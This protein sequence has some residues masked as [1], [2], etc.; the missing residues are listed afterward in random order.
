MTHSDADDHSSVPSTIDNAALQQRL[1]ANRNY[2][3][4]MFGVG[5][6][7]Q[8]MA[9]ALADRMDVLLC[10]LWRQLAPEL[11]DQVDLIAVGGFGRGELAPHS[12]LDLWFLIP[13]S[14]GQAEQEK[15]QPF[16]YALWD[17]NLKVGYAVRSV[18]D[19]VR[20]MSEDWSTATAAMEAR[21]VF[22]H[23]TLFE[24]LQENI[25]KFFQRR[26]AAFV[27]AK[28][29]EMHLRHDRTGKTA[30]LM[31]PDIK[32]GGGS[33]RDIQTVFWLA[34]AWYGTAGGGSLMTSGTLSVRERYHLLAAEDYL[35]RCRVGLHLNQQRA[36][37]RLSFE[38]QAYL[39]DAMGYGGGERPAVE[40]FMKDYFRHA[41]RVV[42][43]CGM[44]TMHFEE[45]Q[46]KHLFVRT[47]PIGHGLVEEG[48]RVGIA[49]AAVFREEPLRLLK[50]FHVA[51]E[52]HRKLTSTTLRRIRADAL[53]I[54]EDV[55]RDP[56]AYQCF[57]DILRQRRNVAWAL[58]E[59]NDTGVLG[60]FIPDFRRVV[61]LGQFN[62]YH[63]YTVDEHTIRAVGEARNF[64]H[65]QRTLR[66]PLA[67]EISA[68]LARPELLYLALIFHDIA[69]G[70]P[71]DHSIEG[72]K[73]AR[74]FCHRAGLD[75]SACD[76][77]PWLVSQHLTMAMVSQR[78]DLSDRA[79]ITDFARKIETRAR[80]DYLYCLTVADIAAVGPEV[81][82]AWKGSL[83]GE[84]YRAA[85]QALLGD[86]LDELSNDAALA[87]RLAQRRQAILALVENSDQRDTLASLACIPAGAQRQLPTK[88]L[89]RM[90][91]F[92]TLHPATDSVCAEVDIQGGGTRVMVHSRERSGL[93]A[94]LTSVIHSS[95]T[96]I[97]SAQAVNLH[98]GRVLDL[99]YLQTIDG[100]PLT[101]QSDLDRLC[102]RIEQVLQSNQ[103]PQLRAAPHFT[104][105]V[106]MRQVTPRV[107][108]LPEASARMIVIE[109]TA[110]SRP[111]ILADLA[112]VINRHHLHTRSA[113]ISTFGEQIVDVFFLEPEGDGPSRPASIDPSLI[114]QLCSDFYQVI[115]LPKE[116]NS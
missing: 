110:A 100:E 31:E 12:D 29:E 90:V 19:C 42:R 76:L 77:V 53:L 83:L 115:T 43:L 108:L 92:L 86:Q 25:H 16:L 45:L 36:S 61:G 102:Q 8:E 114:D 37:D 50:V 87:A 78:Y 73:L 4:E 96:S 75:E 41:G 101:A 30:F 32:E 56:K 85:E 69:K 72:E 44:I 24:A 64:I 17:L 88:I 82:N 26:R 93:F 10:K 95:N 48:E 54:D 22:G 67:S 7:G 47:K 89:A 107:R 39:A 9:Q 27:I 66:S 21:L 33:L 55:R 112:A 99:F 52:G 13:S 35:W 103:P 109:V 84:L 2:I 28:L 11:L 116:E 71:G 80:L 111:G 97:M 18:R 15:I 46:H 65:R 68:R 113:Q 70:I 23:G 51:Q 62:R 74:K 59:M 34:K 60:R 106:L 63:A 3:A 40:R 91:D 49:H 20:A 104:I 1:I 79:V 81:W 105:N 57:M 98:H 94:A 58:K 14:T 5:A 38:Q 6:T